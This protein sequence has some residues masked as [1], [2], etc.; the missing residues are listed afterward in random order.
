MTVRELV[1]KLIEEAPHIDATIYISK[2]S[3]IETKDLDEFAII[4]IDNDGMNDG[5]NID[6]KQIY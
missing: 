6:L 4:R 5:I 3:D 1:M 2:E